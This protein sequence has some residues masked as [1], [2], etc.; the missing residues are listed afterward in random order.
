MDKQKEKSLVTEAET[1][2]NQLIEN[3]KITIP[4]IQTLLKKLQKVISPNNKKIE[5]SKKDL[6]EFIKDKNEIKEFL[7]K[8][9]SNYSILSKAAQKV[10]SKSQP[11]QDNPDKAESR[12]TQTLYKFLKKDLIEAF[13]KEGE[14]YFKDNLDN[15]FVYFENISK[16]KLELNNVP[17]FTLTYFPKEKKINIYLKCNQKMD[18]AFSQVDYLCNSAKE[19][20]LNI[21]YYSLMGNCD[22][23]KSREY[24]GNSIDMAQFE[25]L[26][27]ENPLIKGNEINIIFV[28]NEF[29]KF[30]KEFKDYC[31]S[32]KDK[33][34]S[35]ATNNKDFFNEI[36]I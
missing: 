23:E 5:E 12:K 13:N 28:G 26:I 31:D 20:F 1:F 4:Q 9:D 18:L 10:S 14:K 22:V 36:V 29:E 16:D 17:L 6:S 21:D 11:Q 7:E 33:I 32:L 34:K 19:I 27:K 2:L 35:V 8:N 30:K 3:N 25:K 24:K 15:L